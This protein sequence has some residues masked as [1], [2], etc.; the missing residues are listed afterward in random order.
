[1]QKSA[2]LT[3]WSMYVDWEGSSGMIANGALVLATIMTTCSNI[4]RYHQDANKLSENKDTRVEH[5][6]G[7]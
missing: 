1:M 5:L 7:P 3:E 4:I 2:A 6:V